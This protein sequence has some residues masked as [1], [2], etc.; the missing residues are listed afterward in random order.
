MTHPSRSAEQEHAFKS[1]YEEVYGDLVKFVQRR[2]DHDRAEDVVADVF[3]VVWRR[4]QDAPG[5]LD[6]AR[7]WVFGIARNILLNERRGELRRSALGIRL[8]DPASLPHAT[9]EVEAVVSRVDLSTAWRRLSEVHQEA[10]SLTVFE[11][12]PAPEA[13][14]VIGISPVAFRLRLSRARRALRRH[15]D[16][17]PRA[18]TTPTGLPERTTTS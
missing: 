13:A 17:L 15:L 10:L 12:L 11:G 4:F 3:L 14:V 7:A 5:D 9:A 1:L 16:H 18:N 2:T 8:A 6:G